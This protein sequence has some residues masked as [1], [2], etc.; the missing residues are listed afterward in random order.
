MI[1]TD[2]RDAIER[3]LSEARTVAV[4]GAHP[5]RTKAAHFVPAYLDAQGYRVLPVNP[6]YPDEPLWGRRPVATLAEVTEPVDVVDVFRRSEN[7]AGHE[8]DILAMAPRPKVVWLQQG[9]RD[10]AFAERL[11]AE[12]I[13]V[14]Q[15]ACMMALHKKLGLQTAPTPRGPG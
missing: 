7:V 1:E 6:T 14:V 9:I 15:D 10:D 2:D 3:I 8:A 12:G 4:L 11:E 5:D 13:T